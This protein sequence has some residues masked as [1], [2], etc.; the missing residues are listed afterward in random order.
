MLS[1]DILIHIFL[2]TKMYTKLQKFINSGTKLVNKLSKNVTK[3]VQLQIGFL[4]T[5]FSKNSREKIILDF[6]RNFR[7]RRS[8]TLNNKQTF[9]EKGVSM[10]RSLL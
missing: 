6:L 1:W 10:N 7:E 9:L 4:E 3:E 8:L 5:N 2:T